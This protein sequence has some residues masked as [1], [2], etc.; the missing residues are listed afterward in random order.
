ME[1]ESFDDPELAS[2][3][4]AH[5][6]AVKVDRETRPDIDAIYM[7]AIQALGERGGWPLNVW[8]TPQRKPFFAGTYFPPTDAAGRRSF[9][10]VLEAIHSQWQLDP[11]R[12]EEFA[13]QLSEAIAQSLEGSAPT[14]SRMPTNA[15]LERAAASYAAGAD[16][17]WGGM[18]QRIK[19]PSTLPVRF[20][21]RQQQRAKDADSLA[22][23]TLAL[24]K[25]AAGGIW[26]HVG[27]GF[28]RYSTD[29]KWLVPHFEKM[30]YDNALLAVMYLEAA[31]A[32]GRAE[33]ADVTRAILDY[34]DR[35][36]T[37]PDGVFYSATDA[38][39][40]TPSG[41]SEEG[42]F[43][44]WTPAEIDAALSAEQAAAVK[45]YYG[46]TEAG[47][48]DGRNVLHAWRSTAELA[49]EREQGEAEFAATLDAGRQ[50]LYAVRA[51]RPPPLRDDKILVAWNGLMISALARASFV[52][53]QPE[54]LQRAER[55]ADFLLINA[56]QAGRLRRVYQDGV[57][58][59]PAF[60]EDY[61]FLVAGLL[62]L[63]EAGGDP[64]W[65]AEAIA[66]QSQLDAHYADEV[67]GGY[68]QSA[69]F[70]EKLIAREKPSSDGALPSGN[71][72]ALLN[73]LRLHEFTS[74]TAYHVRAALCFSAFAEALEQQ[75]TA[76]SEMLLALDY[77]LGSTL[78][79]VLVRP[80]QG[81]SADAMLAELRTSFVPN[82]VLAVT[83]EGEDIEALAS[84][85]P[86]VSGKRARQGATTAYV[87]QNRVCQ[88]PTTDP[89]VFRRQLRGSDG[90]E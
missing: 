66:L 24:E 72:V 81:G 87:C 70:Q 83:R 77:Q 85:V 84:I 68:F 41:Q 13:E 12:F 10:A 48:F 18:K 75:P 16:R 79:I 51:R 43:F 60:L 32:T 44:T 6:I 62:D 42:W 38:D 57:A 36:M 39:S 35:E 52:L 23:A 14:E 88:F 40:M 58:S 67:G 78:E 20:L 31:Q 11:K 71:S 29:E 1:E 19:F 89:Q 90:I 63:Y 34:V 61:A 28:H 56:R 3:L 15:V 53:D 82:R 21:L 64:R 7:S 73:L 5:F 69:D 45:A 27:G 65:L 49:A 2:Y 9:R 54:Y 59:G 25:M 80:E 37:S 4:N 33:F 30:L 46:V 76:L 8:V 55:A 50:R 22:M 74:D 86:L 17:E 26:D 47:N